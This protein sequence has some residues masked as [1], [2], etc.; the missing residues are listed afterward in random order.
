MTEDKSLKKIRQ[1]QTIKDV[2]NN[3]KKI[4]VDTSFGMKPTRVSDIGRRLKKLM[5]DDDKILPFG[6]RPGFTQSISVRT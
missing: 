2:S 6:D 4:L 3:S 1:Y 5:C